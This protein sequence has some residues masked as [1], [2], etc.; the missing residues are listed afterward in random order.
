MSVYLSKSCSKQARPSL[1]SFGCVDSHA[2][3]AASLTMTINCSALEPRTTD[4]HESSSSK[5]SSVSALCYAHPKK[6]GWLDTA[7]AVT[8]CHE[9]K[10]SSSL[11][12]RWLSCYPESRVQKCA[13]NGSG[14]GTSS[15]R[16]PSHPIPTR[17]PGCN[18]Q[19]ARTRSS[20]E[21]NEGGPAFTN[22]LMYPSTTADG[23]STIRFRPG[24]RRRN[25]I[26]RD[27]GAVSVI[28]SGLGAPY[29]VCENQLV[30][31]VNLIPMHHA[32]MTGIRPNLGHFYA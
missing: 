14:P 6:R 19:F 9:L 29:R 23:L 5:S 15:R 31:P 1:P 26:P 25:R 20:S 17:L 8:S 32:P 30:L 24:I 13:R 11:R 10:A 4:H 21:D 18:L 22:A 12:T 28:P 3:Q 2:S 27:G 16:I 7:E